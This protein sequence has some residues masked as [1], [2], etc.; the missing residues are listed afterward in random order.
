MK[1]RISGILS[2]MGIMTI[3]L[4]ITAII[5]GLNRIFYGGSET[6]IFIDKLCALYLFLYVILWIIVGLVLLGWLVVRAVRSSVRLLVRL[7]VDL[8][9]NIKNKINESI[10]RKALTKYGQTINED[11]LKHNLHKLDLEI[12]IKNNYS[13]LS[14]FLKWAILFCLEK[15]PEAKLVDNLFQIWCKNE[16]HIVSE[17]SNDTI[18]KIDPL[19]GKIAYTTLSALG[20]CLALDKN[21]ENTEQ[22]KNPNR[23]R[24]LKNITEALNHEIA[25]YN[26][27]INFKNAM[28]IVLQNHELEYL[29]N[30][31]Y[32]KIQDKFGDIRARDIGERRRNT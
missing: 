28:L 20:A 14:L 5:Y 26:D 19:N 9:L 10:I 29:R 7:P 13:E 3:G 4:V 31:L 16:R 21:F 15:M 1:E 32:K 18:K 23:E 24:E 17:I 25:R 22:D 27:F 12:L 8:K 11:I 6:D 30:N 2:F